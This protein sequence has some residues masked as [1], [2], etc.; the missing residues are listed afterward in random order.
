M[1]KTPTIFYPTR[2]KKGAFKPVTNLDEWNSKRKDILSRMETVMGKL[3]IRRKKNIH[4]VY[5]DT[6]QFDSYIRYSVQFEP[7]SS[8]IV[9]AYLYR[10]RN[11]AKKSPAMLALHGTGA[12]GKRIIDGQTS[13]NNR[14]YAKELAERGYVVI[15][16]DYPSMGN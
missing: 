1:L 6:A 16:P 9:Y 14:S 7:A 5:T 2:A 10:P 3:P 15:A 12:D 8:E 4:L 13:K 11:Q